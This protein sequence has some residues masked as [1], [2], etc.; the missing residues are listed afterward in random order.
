MK[1]KILFV[2]CVA[3]YASLSWGCNESSISSHG[4]SATE[5]IEIA[6][7]TIPHGSMDNSRCTSPIISC[8]EGFNFDESG[9]YCINGSE[10][11]EVK[12]TLAIKII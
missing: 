10:V 7:A 3:T 12:A 4:K 8:D 2:A 5:A 9:E 6:Q 1:Y 11:G